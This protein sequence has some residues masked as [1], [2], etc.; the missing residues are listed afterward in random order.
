MA[1]PKKIAPPTVAE[2][3]EIAAGRTIVA[4]QPQLATR[5]RRGRDNIF[6]Q[7]TAARLRR[8]LDGY[9][10]GSLA[11]GAE[12]FA[13]MTERDHMLLNCRT[14]R[15]KQVSRLEWGIVANDRASETDPKFLAQREF[16][17]AFYNG[18]RAVD[19]YDRNKK[20]G[21]RLFLRQLMT[22]EAMG[23]SAHHLVWQPREDGTLGLT[24]EHVPLRFFENVTGELRYCPEGHEVEGQPMPEAEWLVHAGEG[25]MTAASV[26][27]H[28]KRGGMGAF[29]QFVEKFGVPALFMTTA[30]AQGSA[31][32][33]QHVEALE[34]FYN[35]W[36]GVFSAGSD[37][38]PIETHN[39]GQSPHERLID[40]CDRGLA[41]LF[42]G[43]DLATLSNQKSH[44]GQGADLQQTSGQA[45]LEDDA[46]SVEDCL[47]RLTEM[48]LRWKFGPAAPV[49]A[50]FALVIPSPTEDAERLGNAKA[51]RD[52]GAQIDAAELA[53]E[54]DFEVVE[55]G[56]ADGAESAGILPAGATDGAGRQDGGAPSARATVA[57][58]APQGQPRMDFIRDAAALLTGAR[59]ADLAELRTACLAAANASTDVEARKAW[60]SLDARLPD[61]VAKTAAQEAAW[62]DLIATCVANGAEGKI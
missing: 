23:Y 10:N 36:A 54:M 29:V 27:V 21:L 45:L 8:V 12:L 30:A 15:E 2:A 59:A 13:L 61:F 22:A 11:E 46:A 48:A 18:L 42:R 34:A 4:R 28:Y 44:A 6:P 39:T 40:L 17:T 31:E 26:L 53:R 37:L 47:A 41:I 20:G 51:L 57:N 33:D 24:V 62:A 32:W 7:L 16:L 55:G 43:G 50:T 1:R 25:L 5:Y 52:M 14:Q 9:R 35:D 56:P 49:L 60:Q 19:A 3:P 38:K 58:E